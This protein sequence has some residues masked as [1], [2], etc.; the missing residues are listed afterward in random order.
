MKVCTNC[1]VEKP[2]QE[3][4]K[5]MALADRKCHQCK[6]CNK[7]Y[8]ASYYA[9]NKETK[10]AYQAVYRAANKETTKEYHA[11]YRAANKETKLAYQIVYIKDRRASDPLYKLSCNIRSLTAMA[12]KNNGFKKTD[13]TAKILGCTFEHLNHHIETHFYD[14]MTWENQGTY[15][16]V[17][18]FFPISSAATKAD[19]YR[20]S[21]YSNLRPLR[22]H[23]NRMKSDNHPYQITS[24]DTG[25]HVEPFLECDSTYI[26]KKL[27]NVRRKLGERR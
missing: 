2:L 19:V 24:M 25:Y 6:S 20:L 17:D 12:F 27:S 23:M 1:K 3:Y 13:K 14:G 7:A 11:A 8:S 15:W 22:A 21:H 5:N 26:L 10:L 16:H 4:S 9:A 18:H